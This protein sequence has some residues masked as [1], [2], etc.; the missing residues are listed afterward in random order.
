MVGGAIRSGQAVGETDAT[1]AEP[2][3][4]GFTPDDLAASFYA[5]LGI[6]LATEFLSNVGRPIVLVRDGRPIK[7]LF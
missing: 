7:T 6:D 4:L 5:N 1:A 3:G 2:L